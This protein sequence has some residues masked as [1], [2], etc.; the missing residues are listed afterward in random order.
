MAADEEGAEILDI[1][2]ETVLTKAGGAR[3]WRERSGAAGVVDFWANV[4]DGAGAGV[5][6]AVAAGTEGAGI[7]TI[8]LTSF[9]SL[10]SLASLD[11]W[12]VNGL[13]IALRA[14]K[15]P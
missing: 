1:G 11:C 12:R 13:F 3:L 15:I 7:E 9:L 14:Y 4:S 6:V 8:G 5:M 2:A 10:S